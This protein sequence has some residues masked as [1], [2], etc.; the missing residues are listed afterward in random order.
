M[1]KNTY[2]QLQMNTLALKHR[3]REHLRQQKFELERLERSYR[4]TLIPCVILMLPGRKLHKQIKAS[5][6]RNAVPPQSISREG[7]FKLDVDDDIWQDTGLNDEPIDEVPLWLVNNNI[8]ESIRAMLELD[9]C[10]KEWKHLM[11]ERCMMQRWFDSVVM[12]H[13]DCYAAYICNLCITW[14][15]KTRAVLCT[16]VMLES[17]GPSKEDL[18]IASFFQYR[19]LCDS[20]NQALEQ[21]SFVDTS[22]ATVSSIKN[23]GSYSEDGELFEA[24]ED[25]AFMDEYHWGIGRSETG[26]GQ[27]LSPAHSPVKSSPR[28]RVRLLFA[29]E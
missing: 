4:R 10:K 15:T 21:V 24:V 1:K 23:D 6:P 25:I 5:A 13:L 20:T 18:C 7:L 28:K 14:Q 19:A 22:F 11:E 29:E 27:D 12:Y 17:W 16:W 9:R 3:I 2:L 26:V 8:Q